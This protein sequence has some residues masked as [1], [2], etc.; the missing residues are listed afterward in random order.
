M[1]PELCRLCERPVAD[2]GYLAAELDLQKLHEWCLIF[3]GTS[4][5]ENVRDDDMICYFCTWDAKFLLDNGICDNTICWWPKD[6]VLQKVPMMIY[7]NYTD[8]KLKQCWVSL[9]KL[10]RVQCNSI[11]SGQGKKSKKTAKCIYC[12]KHYV[13]S[14]NL[15]LHVNRM[16]KHVALKCDFHKLCVTFFKTEEDRK[17]HV[18]KFHMAPQEKILYDCPE[19]AL[20][21]KQLYDHARHNHPTKVNQ[22]KI[23]RCGVYFKTRADLDLH[24]EKEHKEKNKFTCHFCSYKA[25]DKEYLLKHKFSKHYKSEKKPIRCSKCPAIYKFQA[26]LNLH[27][28]LAH[29]LRECYTCRTKIK[30]GVFNYH[31]TKVSCFKCGARFSCRG[32]LLAHQKGCKMSKFRCEMCSKV[33]KW[34]NFLKRHI[35]KDHLM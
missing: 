33:F 34:K 26:S 35:S 11:Q 16:H 13:N 30:A 27:L 7:E 28:Y 24:F 9:E 15:V 14:N 10:K 23:K 29:K 18:E 31:I 3:L 5:S 32:A 19:T 22:C 25:R 21:R 1:F 8:A 6:E 2:G 20:P 4:L 17:L 12:L